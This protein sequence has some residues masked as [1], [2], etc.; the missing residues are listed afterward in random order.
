MTAVNEAK[1]EFTA[2]VLIIGNEILSGRTQDV[3]LAYIAQRLNT[4]GIR[5]REA[6]VVADIEHAIVKAVNECRA[7][8]DYVFTTGGIGPTHDDITSEC[9]AKAFGQRYV[10]NERARAILLRRY[11]NPA[12]LNA[13]RLRMATMAEGAEL[14][15]N[16]IS[17]APGYR[18]GNVYVLAGIPKVMQAMFESMA[19]L[20]TG[21]APILSRGVSAELAEG[22]I[23][24]D[25][26]ALQGRFSELDIGSYP[27]YRQGRFGTAIVMRGTER[28][29]IDAC[30]EELKVFM[31]RLGGD[32]RDEEV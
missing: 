8:Y 27:W 17:G 1:R 26:T 24:A 21:G 6:R 32:P 28:T 12:D 25:L 19:H 23:A 31:R 20:L 5:L 18:V 30:A 13:A 9:V 7:A 10:V 15:E 4:L 29:R 3:N 11:A 22:V 14:I 16:P 2:C